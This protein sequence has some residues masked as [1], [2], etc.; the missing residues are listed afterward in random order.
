MPTRLSGC[1]TPGVGIAKP[2][3]PV[4]ERNFAKLRHITLD[5]SWLCFH[6]FILLAL[7]ILLQS[8]CA[9]ASTLEYCEYLGETSNHW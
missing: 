3:K 9:I 8:R 4:M 1:E 2:I 6:E 7:A 5:L